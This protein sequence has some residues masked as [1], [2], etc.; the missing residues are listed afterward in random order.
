MRPSFLTLFLASLATLALCPGCTT[1]TDPRPAATVHRTVTFAVTDSLGAAAPNVDVAVTTPDSAGVR[2]HVSLTTDAA[3]HCTIAL[4]QGSAFVHAAGTANQ[5]AGS[6]VRVPGTDRALAD[7]LLVNLALHTASR[8]SGV[9]MLQAKSDPSGTFVSVNGFPA[10][11]IT[12]STG[13]YLVAGLP[14]GH[15]SVGF[16]HRGYA[17]A[18]TAIDVVQPASQLSIPAVLLAVMTREP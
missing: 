7:T 6:S 2:A 5:V 9:V 14:P 16:A 18:F 11:A 15:W 1:P 10:L 17:D 8:A 13:A 4:R 3:G 12:D